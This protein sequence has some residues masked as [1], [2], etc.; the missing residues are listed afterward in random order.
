MPL[1]SFLK[2]L[3]MLEKAIKYSELFFLVSP[4]HRN[5]LVTLGRF[6]LPTFGL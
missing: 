2:R 5:D 1:E 6:E 4:N 3:E